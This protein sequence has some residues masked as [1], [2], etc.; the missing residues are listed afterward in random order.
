M[1]QSTESATEYYALLFEDDGELDDIDDY[2]IDKEERIIELAVG[3]VYIGRLTGEQFHR[4]L[5]RYKQESKI[6]KFRY[7]VR[8]VDKQSVPD[9]KE[10]ELKLRLVGLDANR[11]EML[12]TA[13]QLA[14]VVR[15]ASDC[16][17]ENILGE[18]QTELTDADPPLLLMAP[19]AYPPVD[20]LTMEKANIEN[21]PRELPFTLS[22]VA[23]GVPGSSSETPL[24]IFQVSPNSEAKRTEP[25]EEWIGS[26]EAVKLLDC[27]RATL[28]K[29]VK[30]GHIQE[31]REGGK[32]YYL[33]S[34]VLECK[35]KN[36]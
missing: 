9:R 27:A 34:S 24:Y 26:A 16:E 4:F 7:S 25:K 1:E 17:N 13:L 32:T 30:D 12:D 8:F 22:G 21:A 11:Q 10:T 15:K 31:R 6:R 5:W 20:T 35:R 2:D 19:S 29:R 3:A 18:C 33:K 14:N 23:P 36:P 28:R